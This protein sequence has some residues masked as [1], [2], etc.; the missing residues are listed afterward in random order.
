[1]RNQP[2]DEARRLA[3]KALA[4]IGSLFYVGGTVFPAYR[5]LTSKHRNDT[6]VP[7]E[8]VDAGPASSLEPGTARMVRYGRRPAVVIRLASGELRGYIA[9]CTHLDCTVGYNPA[10]RH[11]FCACHGARFAPEDG[12]VLNGPADR[13][14]SR[15][16]VNL[17]ND[18]I[19]LTLPEADPT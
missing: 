6:T 11:I 12:S 2:E 13:P 7:P 3:L 14:L 15:L 16:Q 10:Q 9:V 4:A 8:F 18:T 1:M 17:D 5:F 19:I